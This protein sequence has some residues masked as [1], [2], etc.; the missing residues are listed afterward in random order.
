MALAKKPL[1]RN[2]PKYANKGTNDSGK[3]FNKNQGNKGKQQ[4]VTRV[5]K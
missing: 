3:T 1:D 4:N 5:K 2:D